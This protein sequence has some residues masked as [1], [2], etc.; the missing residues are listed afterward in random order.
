MA[1]MI[2]SIIGAIHIV[3]TMVTI[4]VGIMV[5]IVHIVGV[6]AILT[7]T[8]TTIAITIATTIHTITDLRTTTHHIRAREA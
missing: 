8:I 5:G 1:G 7:H 2:H 4:M 3:T 6:G